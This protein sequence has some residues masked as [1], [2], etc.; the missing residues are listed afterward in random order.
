M[1]ATRPL[2]FGFRVNSEERRMI[3][4]LAEKLERPQGDAVRYLVRKAAREL[5]PQTTPTNT[6]GEP[7]REC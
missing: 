1:P 5:L 6:G 4:K 7:C 3:E 2:I